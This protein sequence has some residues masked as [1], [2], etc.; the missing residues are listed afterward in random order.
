MRYFKYS[1]RK[2]NPKI[3]FEQIA[4]TLEELT[5]L[6]LESRDPYVISQDDM[7]LISFEHGRFMKNVDEGGTL[8]DLS[9]EEIEEAETTFLPN[10]AINLRSQL[11]TKAHEIALATKLGELTTRLD[12]EFTTL[13][14]AYDRATT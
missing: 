11:I 10:L 13:E 8:V 14:T 2:D 6:G 5:A 12:T 4:Q 3:A 9:T 7:E 1:S